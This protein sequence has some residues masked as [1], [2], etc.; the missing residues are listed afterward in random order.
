VVAVVTPEQTVVLGYGATTAGGTTRPDGDTPFQVASLSK[1]YTGLALARQVANGDLTPSAPAGTIVGADLATALAG[2]SFTLADLAT[3]HAGFPVFPSNLVDRDGDGAPD[4]GADPLSPATGYAR[5]DLERFLSG[6]TPTPDAPYAYSNLGA[7]LLGIALTDDL[8]LSSYHALLRRLVADDLGMAQTWGAVSVMDAGAQARV[9]QGYA[10]QKGVR[11]P[12]LLAEM[13]VL[14]GG[15]EIVT[16]GNDLAS[17][18]VALTGAR[19]TALD[20]A[21][22]IAVTPVASGPN[23]D[24]EL[25]Y[26]IEIE[27]LPDGDRFG[28]AGGTASYTS[29]LSFRRAPAVGVVVMTSCGGF[30]AVRDLATAIDDRITALTR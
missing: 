22:A 24:T 12:G 23:A 7:G 9:A 14:A 19:P 6:F 3:H 4:P 20:D 15:G 11:V 29:Y 27:H 5:D 30:T 1:V 18:L 2:T 25:G 8:R 26:A 10:L 28:K 13:G 17:L 16:T 21:A